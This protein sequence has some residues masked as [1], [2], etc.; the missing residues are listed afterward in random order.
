M[1]ISARLALNNHTK[2]TKEA[3]SVL[4]YAGAGYRN[5]S[6][7]TILDRDNPD[8]NVGADDCACS[9]HIQRSTGELQTVL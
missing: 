3:Y 7:L 5:G 8:L 9:P 2:Y 1:A 6:S 4:N